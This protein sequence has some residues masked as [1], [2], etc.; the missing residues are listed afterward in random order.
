MNCRGMTR[1]S[2]SKDLGHARTHSASWVYPLQCLA[3]ICLVDCHTHKYS[4]TADNSLWAPGSRTVWR[5][6]CRKAASSEGS[7]GRTAP[8]AMVAEEPAR[9]GPATVNELPAQETCSLRCH[10]HTHS[11][12][13]GDTINAIDSINTIQ[14]SI[15]MMVSHIVLFYT[16]IILQNRAIF[17]IWRSLK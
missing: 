7:I 13:V 14:V 2:S 10:V 15:V 16:H 3:P 9:G 6:A 4:K 12:V 17:W 5:M 1:E 11:V 8:P